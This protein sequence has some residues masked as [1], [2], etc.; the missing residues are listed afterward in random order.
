MPSLNVNYSVSEDLLFYGN[1]SR[2]FSNPNLEETLTPDGTTNPDIAQETGVNYELGTTMFADKKNLKIN[3][4]L[5]QMNIKNLLV[6]ERIGNDEFIGRN[7]GSTVHKGIELDVKY[8]YN[9]TKY[10]QLIHFF[11]Y[12]YN[13]HKFKDFV[14]E[15]DN[16]SGN[17]L[18]GVPKHRL[19]SGFG[20]RA[21]N[22]LFWNV[23]HQYVGE[24]PLTDGNTLYSE[25]YSVFNFKIGYKTAISSNLNLGLSFG[26]N[27][28]LDAKYAQ[29]VLI[30][31]SSFGGRAPRYYY[32][33]NNRNWYGGL[34]LRYRL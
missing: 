27:N 2:G 31:A 15:G 14:D 4:S 11:G 22:G 30:N 33:G 19:S 1:I 25:T 12:T 17:W 6:A 18:T 24:I 5:Y 16:F 3:V 28:M 10:I 8:I 21:K 7:A 23:N 29:S 32:P 26:V 9:L 34:R 13:H 20:L